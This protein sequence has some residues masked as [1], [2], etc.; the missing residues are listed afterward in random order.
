[1]FAFVC[2]NCARGIICVCWPPGGIQI[3][4]RT[5]CREL[6]SHVITR[7]KHDVTH[8][9]TKT[10]GLPLAACR[11]CMLAVN[12]ATVLDIVYKANKWD[13]PSGNYHTSVI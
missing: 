10:R 7:D 5:V 1:L 8:F 11:D 6:N 12:I 9:V 3:A 2:E 13:M 4:M